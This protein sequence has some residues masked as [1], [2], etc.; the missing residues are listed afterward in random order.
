MITNTICLSA[1]SSA[2][3]GLFLASFRLRV[4]N[5][6][7]CNGPHI[8]FN[9]PVHADNTHELFMNIDNISTDARADPS[10]V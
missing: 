6:L 1:F 7:V 2:T 3:F 4:K 8:F 10:D 5:R 9:L